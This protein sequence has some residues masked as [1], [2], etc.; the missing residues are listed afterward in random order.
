MTSQRSPRLISSIEREDV[1]ILFATD[2]GL[3]VKRGCDE[4][5]LCRLL[6]HGPEN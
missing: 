1:E 5:F 2:V 6:Q 4:E 3:K